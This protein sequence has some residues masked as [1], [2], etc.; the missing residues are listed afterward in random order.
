MGGTV[1]ISH[2][3]LQKNLVGETSCHLGSLK[4]FKRLH[5]LE[6]AK[7]HL[8]DY[9]VSQWESKVRIFY[10][11]ALLTSINVFLS[12]TIT[13]VNFHKL[14]VHIMLLQQRIF[15]ADGGGY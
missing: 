4:I 9:Q 12:K 2:I 8:R 5:E 10:F 3:S 11:F 13:K 1:G 6:H 7:Q 15:P 14:Q